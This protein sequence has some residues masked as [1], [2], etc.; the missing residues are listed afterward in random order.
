MC[1]YIYTY[2]YEYTYILILYLLHY[3]VWLSKLR[4]FGGNNIRL[5]NKDAVQSKGEY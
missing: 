3:L 2:T 4:P 1:L 5:A